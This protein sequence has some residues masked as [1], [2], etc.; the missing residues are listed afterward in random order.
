MNYEEVKGDLPD[1]WTPFK[2]HD[3]T[4]QDYFKLKKIEE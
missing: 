3:A 1:A 2:F 4:E